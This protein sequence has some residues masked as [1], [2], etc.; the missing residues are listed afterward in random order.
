MQVH[1]CK[2]TLSKRQVCKQL[3]KV[4]KKLMQKCKHKYRFPSR[5]VLKPDVHTSTEILEDFNAESGADTLFSQ[6]RCPK[7]R[8]AQ[9]TA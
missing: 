1:E 8:L 9:K 6:S 5:S 4:L 2:I 7:D 3:V